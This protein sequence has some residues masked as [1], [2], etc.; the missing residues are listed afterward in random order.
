MKWGLRRFQNEDGSLT[1]EG[2]RRYAKLSNKQSK[3]EAKSK[4]LQARIKSNEHALAKLEKKK[5]KLDLDYIESR[6]D[7]AMKLQTKID[8]LDLDIKKAAAK[9][10]KS[11]KYQAKLKVKI[12]DLKNIDDAF[13]EKRAKEMLE[14]SKNIM[15]ASKE[16]SDNAN[17]AKQR[18]KH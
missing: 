18:E 6:S 10:A 3:A 15:N 13:K 5:N 1:E 16:I 11:E 4:K 12:K 7:K 8:K 9:L 17:V 14:V 2:R